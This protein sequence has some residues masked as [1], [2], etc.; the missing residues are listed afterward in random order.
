L[1][2]LANVLSVTDS[3][4]LAMNFLTSSCLAGM[5][6]NGS[7]EGLVQRLWDKVAAVRFDAVQNYD[8]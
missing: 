6:I 7:E 4:V 1:K 3:S 2:T 8:M 5:I